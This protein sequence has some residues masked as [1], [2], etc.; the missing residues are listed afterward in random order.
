MRSN[1]GRLTAAP[2]GVVFFL[3]GLLV[4]SWFVQFGKVLRLAVEFFGVAV[5]CLIS[6]S[7]PH[8]RADDMF[9][10]MPNQPCALRAFPMT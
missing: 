3:R 2:K 1:G 7:W 8:G 9:G 5:G 4:L 6:W 10:G